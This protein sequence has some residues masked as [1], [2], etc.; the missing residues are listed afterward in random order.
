MPA[1]PASPSAANAA[2]V[3]TAAALQRGRPAHVRKASLHD[4]KPHRAFMTAHQRARSS[5]AQAEAGG[6]G[7]TSRGPVRAEDGYSAAYR[8]CMAAAEGFTVATS[9]CRSAELARQG[10]RL[11]RAYEAAGAGRPA[12]QRAHLQATQ[13]EWAS[14]RDA[15]CQE[16]AR[17]S[18]AHLL[19]E[20][21]CRLDKTIERA[22]GLA[23]DAG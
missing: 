1:A 2:P 6:Q 16:Q 18:G 19:E 17:R 20:G 21:S 7:R 8:S 4:A 22:N 5:T 14:R 11:D 23:R 12:D 9:N 3:G 10:E 15:D 13:Q